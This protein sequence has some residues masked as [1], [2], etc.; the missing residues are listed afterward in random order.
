MYVEIDG[1][2]LLP[3]KGRSVSTSHLLMFGPVSA[4]KEVSMYY[5][6]YLG[7]LP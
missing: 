2:K 1:E 7:S 4:A 6:D 3:W 5:P